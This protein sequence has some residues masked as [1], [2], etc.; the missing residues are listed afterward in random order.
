MDEFFGEFGGALRLQLQSAN[1]RIE[2][3]RNDM[4]SLRS[5]KSAS[6]GSDI[7]DVPAVTVVPGSLAGACFADG[8]RVIASD[9]AGGREVRST[10]VGA[11]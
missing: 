5:P 7:V 1:C 10:P 9:E 4:R 3:E 11:K 6:D 8:V 2:V